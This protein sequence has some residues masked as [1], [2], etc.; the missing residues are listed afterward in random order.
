MVSNSRCQ[1][2]RRWSEPKHESRKPQLHYLRVQIIRILKPQESHHIP[3]RFSDSNHKKGLFDV[4]CQ[5]NLV[6]TKFNKYVEQLWC[7]IR[8]CFKTVVQRL[9]TSGWFGWSIVHNSQL[10][11]FA[12]SSDYSVVGKVMHSFVFFPLDFLYSDL[13]HNSFVHLFLDDLIV[14]V[15][16]FWFIFRCKFFRR[17][18]HSS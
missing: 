1:Y 8:P 14:L 17:P 7:I 4:G 18:R 3:V 6:P 2:G 13:F 5:T 11:R 9:I 15:D 12:I 16:H 10:S